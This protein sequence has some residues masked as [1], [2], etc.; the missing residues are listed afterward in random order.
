[1]IRRFC[2]QVLILAVATMLTGFA[3][4]QQITGDIRGVVKDAS[5]AAIHGATVQV[6]N[7][8]RNA[9]LREI[10]SGPDGTYVATQLPVGHYQIVVVAP[11]FK[12]LVTKDVVL[13]VNDHLIV[14]APLQVGANSEVVNVEES[15]VAVNTET[16]E[17]AGVLNGTQIRE[18]SV[19]SRNFVQLVTLQPGVASDMATDQLYVGAS[20]PTGY[21]N[22]INLAINGSRPSQNSFLIDGADD[23]QRGADLLLLAFPSIDSIAEFKVDRS[24]FLPEHGRTS[25][26]EVSVITRGG[27]N[28]FHGNAYEFF[29]NDFLNAND[30]FNNR[31]TP[32]TPRPPMRWNDWGFTFGGPIQKNKTFFFYSQEW[33]HFITYTDFT[34][35][36][37]GE[38]PSPAEMNGTFPFAVCLPRSQYRILQ[39]CKQHSD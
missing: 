6:I 25:S 31:T 5:G 21:S 30:Y 22:Q 24:N 19:L 7:T 28:S 3:A 23:M 10:E 34:T 33:R 17:S 16:S 8:E 12:K 18:L 26:G 36:P 14:D 2:F 32:P 4:A 27:T 1:M 13:N 11:G 29:R 20:N 35:S 15:P 9:V 37:Y 39:Q 38:L